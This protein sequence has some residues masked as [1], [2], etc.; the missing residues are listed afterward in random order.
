[1]CMMYDVLCPPT[2]IINAL[3]LHTHEK[4]NE[5]MKIGMSSCLLCV[6]AFNNKLLS[7]TSFVPV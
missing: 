4:I 6:F 5:Y 3:I 7:R 2:L 1:M